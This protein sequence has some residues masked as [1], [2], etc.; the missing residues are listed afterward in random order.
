MFKAISL[1]SLLGRIEDRTKNTLTN[2]LKI[3]GKLR[4][5]VQTFKE[6]LNVCD[7]FKPLGY[8]V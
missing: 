7:T 5:S 3:F 1:V 6:A 8:L 4:I 2:A